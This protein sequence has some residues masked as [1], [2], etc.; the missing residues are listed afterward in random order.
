MRPVEAIESGNKF[1]SVRPFVRKEGFTLTELIIVLTIIA[2]L[3]AIAVMSLTGF[4]GKGETTACEADQYAL[5]RAVVAFY[6]EAD[7]WPT[8][9][10]T[11]DKVIDWEAEDGIGNTFVPDYVLEKPRSDGNYH[12]KIDGSGNVVPSEGDCSSE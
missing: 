12:W 3:L 2:M 11:L 4:I 7:A 8:D 1:A 10:G 6:V 9:G 5:Q